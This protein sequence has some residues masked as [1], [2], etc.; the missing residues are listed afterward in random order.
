MTILSG[1]VYQPPGASYAPPIV[2]TPHSGLVDAL[3]AHSMQPISSGRPNYA[4]AMPSPEILKAISQ[5]L[6]QGSGALKSDNGGPGDQASAAVGG[7]DTPLNRLQ[8]MLGLG[9]PGAANMVP[10]SGLF[11]GNALGTSYASAAAPGP[12]QFEPM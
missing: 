10:G 7:T 1:P 9:A 5:W 8:G 12:M 6:Q 2:E 4:S 11:G 3:L